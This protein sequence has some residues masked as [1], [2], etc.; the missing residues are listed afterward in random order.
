MSICVKS[1]LGE[2]DTNIYI[3]HNVKTNKMDTRKAI[4]LFMEA[5]PFSLVKLVTKLVSGL[6]VLKNS[7]NNAEEIELQLT[8]FKPLYELRHL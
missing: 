3:P 4:V 7:K 2:W 6:S 5:L 1:N 8:S